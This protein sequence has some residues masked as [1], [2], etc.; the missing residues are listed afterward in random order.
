M[1]AAAM[2]PCPCGYFNDKS[3][4][5]LCTP[6]M[7]QCYVSKVYGPLLD[8]IDIHIEV[9]AVQYEEPRGGVSAE[10]RTRVLGPARSSTPLFGSH[11]VLTMYVLTE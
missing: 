2:N 7:I 11:C 1:L 5:C 9:P 4:E 6:P 10:I 3:R 8:L